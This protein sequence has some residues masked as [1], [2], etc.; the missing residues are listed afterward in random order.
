MMT[1]T[2]LDVVAVAA[3]F[4][5]LERLG[6]IVRHPRGVLRGP[7]A[8]A[9]LGVATWTLAATG[10]HLGVMG[11]TGVLVLAA[12][13]MI[14]S[15]MVVLAGT[16]AALIISYR[17]HLVTHQLLL[18]SCVPVLAMVGLLA[19]PSTRSLVV[20]RIEQVDGSTVLQWGPT[21]WAFTLV[22]GVFVGVICALG[23]GATVATV[24]GQRAA[25][26][27]LMVMIAPAGV[28][29]AFFVA[30]PVSGRWSVVPPLL[31]SLAM[32][33][34]TWMQRRVPGLAHLPIT[35]VRVMR[36][37]QNGVVVLTP[38]LVVLE[39]NA[40][41]RAMFADGPHR[42]EEDLVGRRWEQV[43]E[44]ALAALPGVGQTL[45]STTRQGRVLELTVEDVG[46][47][48]TLPALVVAAADVTE[49]TRLRAHLADQAT[50]DPMTGC[51]N[52]RFLDQRIPTLVARS[53]QHQDSSVLMLDIDRFKAVN[54]QHGHAMG[55]RVVIAVA[56][57]ATAALPP[58]GD[59][60]RTGGDEFL[61]LL[62]DTDVSG[63]R[64][65]GDLVRRRCSELQFATHG[66]PV[67]IT[68]SAGVAQCRPGMTADDLLTAVDRALYRA[69]NDGRDVTR[70]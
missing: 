3:S 7:L 70:A 29:W 1:V 41:A 58:G 15:W 35:A 14:G 53:A 60:V 47:D 24:P 6:E 66:A 40:A 34:W 62:P 36:E 38:D 8:L 46:G 11:T 12:L 42:R 50:R 64:A 39:T 44:P 4:V 65:I 31:L 52:R 22:A 21:F 18:I 2:V 17:G 49:L 67:R 26:V 37:V 9:L 27:L 51:R 23:V 68:V 19:T 33:G 5:A 54:D 16:W 56:E 25:M 10:V 55:D 45:R 28:T 69:K 48:G 59:L 32:L 30:D 43:V 57:E 13:E 20:V 61:L 63:A